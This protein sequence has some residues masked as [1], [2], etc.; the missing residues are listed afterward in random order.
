MFES[1]LGF[2]VAVERVCVCVLALATLHPANPSANTRG[3]VPEHQ[4]FV[5][6]HVVKSWCYFLNKSVSLLVGRQIGRF[7]RR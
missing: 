7:N 4:Q 3:G 6:L 5:F 2:R 1:S